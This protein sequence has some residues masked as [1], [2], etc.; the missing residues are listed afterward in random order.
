[1]FWSDDAIALRS[2]AE[3][4]WQKL[5]LVEGAIQAQTDQTV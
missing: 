4:Q 3:R 5:E 1:M 2:F